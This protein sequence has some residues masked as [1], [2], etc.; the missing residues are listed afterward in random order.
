MPQ[1]PLNTPVLFIIFNHQEPQTVFNDKRDIGHP[2]L[3]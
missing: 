2:A 3:M 1:P